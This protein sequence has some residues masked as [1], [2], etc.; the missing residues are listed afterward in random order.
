L[1][2]SRIP[3]SHVESRLAKAEALQDHSG[4]LM[5]GKNDAAKIGFEPSAKSARDNSSRFWGLIAGLFFGLIPGAI[6]VHLL[7]GPQYEGL[8]IL[9]AEVAGI[10]AAVVAL[11][12]RLRNQP[13]SN[14][15]AEE[16]K[17]LKAVLDSA[18][19]LPESGR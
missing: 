5:Q 6:L 15:G 7:P 12:M 18:L 8:L 9:I 16:A 2:Y 10:A 1:S 4:G 11:R 3:G 19:H 17:P 13:D 14:G